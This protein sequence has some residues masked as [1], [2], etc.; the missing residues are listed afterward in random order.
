M[1]II[2]RAEAIERG[3]KRY[4]TGEA[5]PRGHVAERSVRGTACIEC[6]KAASRA[7]REAH[8]EETRATERAYAEV[9]REELNAA[10]RAY[11]EAHLE[12]RLAQERAYR[13]AH[14][15]ERKAY[16]RARRE[17]CGEELCARDRARRAELLAASIE[18]KTLQ[19]RG[20]TEP[21][22]ISEA[23]ARL[24]VIPAEEARLTAMIT[25][26]ATDPIDPKKL[27]PS[28]TLDGQKRTKRSRS[29]NAPPLDTDSESNRATRKGG[30]SV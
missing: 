1:G 15:E 13:E 25:K 3:L 28:I 23:I 6:Q 21:K 18:L 12:K 8:Y 17:A 4:F 22:T 11:R 19:D 5:C 9:H 29:R 14:R 20:L 30:R 10:S 7:Y 24:A 16:D 27:A 26:A 2:T